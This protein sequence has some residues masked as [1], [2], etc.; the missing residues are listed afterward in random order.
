MNTERNVDAEKRKA[1][2]KVGTVLLLIFG[3]FLYDTILGHHKRENDTIPTTTLTTYWLK[4]PGGCRGIYRLAYSEWYVSR[5]DSPSKF[6][7]VLSDLRPILRKYYYWLSYEY[8]QSATPD[9]VAES[10]YNRCSDGKV[11]FKV[12]KTN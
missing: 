2:I 9:Y 5:V 10:E 6:N 3:L 4:A 1:W 8:P 12:V 11:Y 7:R